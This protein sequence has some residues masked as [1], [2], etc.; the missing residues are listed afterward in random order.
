MIGFFFA[1][2]VMALVQPRPASSDRPLDAG[3]SQALAQA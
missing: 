1:M 2:A 3:V